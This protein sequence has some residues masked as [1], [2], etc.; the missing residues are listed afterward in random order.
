MTVNQDD[1]H[2]TGIY[3]KIWCIGFIKSDMVG[4]MNGF[5]M[6]KHEVSMQMRKSSLLVRKSG[7]MVVATLID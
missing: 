4:R 3:V 6:K 7:W 1:G 5:G 2:D